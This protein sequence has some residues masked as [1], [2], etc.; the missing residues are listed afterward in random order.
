MEELQGRGILE[1]PLA[2]IILNHGA[3]GPGTG[4]EM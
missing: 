4:R 1:G 3:A 2:Y